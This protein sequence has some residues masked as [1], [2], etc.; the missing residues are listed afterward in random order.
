LAYGSN[1]DPA[2]FAKYLQGG[3][4]EPGARDATPPIADRWFDLLFRLD[5]A[6]ASQ[7]WS[8]GGVAFVH[9]DQ[10]HRTWFRGWHITAEQFEDVFAQ[11]NRL[12]VGTGL[13][14]DDFGPEQHI[15]VGTGWYRRIH[16]LGEISAIFGLDDDCLTFT[17]AEVMPFNPP[18]GDYA[19]TIRQGLRDHP[20]LNEAE[21][22]AYLTTHT[23]R[24]L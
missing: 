11:E 13:P 18:H 17:S 7:R 12:P 19:N 1:V 10:R 2:R 8:G 20:D 6:G 14:W 4:T 9:P 22:D 5:F 23:S 3:E 24:P 21:I 15:D 16:L